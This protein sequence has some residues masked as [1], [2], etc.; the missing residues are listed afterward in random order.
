MAI[1]LEVSVLALVGSVGFKP[2]ILAVLVPCL[3]CQAKQTH[4]LM[5]V[6]NFKLVKI[7]KPAFES[8]GFYVNWFVRCK[9]CKLYSGIEKQY[10]NILI[11]IHIRYSPLYFRFILEKNL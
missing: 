4:K 3:A 11:P 10:G 8:P 5:T 9:I 1:T 6:L 2:L 7:E